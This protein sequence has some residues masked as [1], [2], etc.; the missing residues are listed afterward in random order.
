M[1][2]GAQAA[3]PPLRDVPGPSAYGGGTQRFLNLLWLVST[4]DFRLTFFGTV[5]GFLW[6][7]VRPLMLFAVLYFVFSK[8]FRIEV[9]HYAVL[10][11]LNLM[12]FNFFLDATNRSVE[13]VLKQ[14]TVVRKMQFPRMVIPLSVVLTSLFTLCLNMIVVFVFILA[15]GVEPMSTWLLLPFIV[16][17]LVAFTAAMSMILSSLF[18]RYRDVGQ[19]WSVLGFVFLYG[20]PV[21]YPASFLVANAPD[22]KWILLVNPFAPLLQQAHRWII[23]PTAPTV[24]TNTGSYWGW[25]GPALVFCAVCAFAVWVFN[26]QAPRIAEEL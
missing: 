6:T 23:D 18:P 24:V 5:L 3:A 21:L 20:S 10:L 16:L 9:P 7:L 4:T 14:E 15:S 17:P 8:V 12:L 11:L 2:V 1:S 25:I 26:R 22:F 13:S 19:I